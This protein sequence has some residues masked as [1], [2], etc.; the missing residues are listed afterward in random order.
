MEE[1]TIGDC[2]DYVQEYIDNQKK[3]SKSSV[4]KATQED[5]DSF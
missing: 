4:R 1:M 3:E 5:F 2:L